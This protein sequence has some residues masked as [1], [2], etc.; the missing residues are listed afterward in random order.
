MTS[1]ASQ[2]PARSRQPYNIANDRSDAIIVPGTRPTLRA[3]F[4]RATPNPMRSTSVRPACTAPVTAAISDSSPPARMAITLYR[5]QGRITT[6]SI[7]STAATTPRA[8][9]PAPSRGGDARAAM[10][11]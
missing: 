6:A 11:G 2:R 4:R 8:G 1:S 9:G 7:T 10:T 5:Y 3:S